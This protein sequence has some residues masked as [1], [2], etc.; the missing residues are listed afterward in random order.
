MSRSPSE[1]AKKRKNPFDKWQYMSY[2]E[3][4]WNQSF[5]IESFLQKEGSE[6]V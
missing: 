5:C 6:Y 4:V 2:N 1:N 3:S